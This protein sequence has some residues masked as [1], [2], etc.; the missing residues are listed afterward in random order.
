MIARLIQDL[1]IAQVEHATSALAQPRG[2][3]A[4]E[5]GRAVGIYAGLT[6]A[7]ERIDQILSDEKHKD[8]D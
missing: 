8:F 2:A 1:K 3:D 6:L 5:Y 4:Y 7:L